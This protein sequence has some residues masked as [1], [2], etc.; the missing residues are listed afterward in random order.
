MSKHVLFTTK[1]RYMIIRCEKVESLYTDN[2]VKNIKVYNIALY[3]IEGNDKK[4]K[5]IDNISANKAIADTLCGLINGNGLDEVHI[6]DVI[7]DVLCAG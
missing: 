6:N 1:E 4:L 7:E 3:P 5:T 2:E